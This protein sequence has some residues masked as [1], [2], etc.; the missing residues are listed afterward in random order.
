M[1]LKT[2][3]LSIGYNNNTLY[4]NLN[5]TL[6]A[7]SVT[8]M[9]GVNGSGKST[10][11]KT[12]CGFVPP[13]HG[14]ILYS[15]KSITHYT[16]SELASIL[17]VVLTDRDVNGGLRVMEVVAM[18]RYPYTN[19]FGT[20]SKI[21]I[22]IIHSSMVDVGIEHLKDRFMS[23]L[24]DGER[25]KVMIAKSLSQQSKLIIL[26]E[27]TSFLD[28]KS[29]MEIVTLLRKL[30]KEKNRTFLLSLHDLELSLQYADY[31]WILSKG[32]GV[33]CGSTDEMVLSSDMDKAVG[34]GVTFDNEKGVYVPINCDGVAI[35]YEGKELIWIKNALRREGYIIDSNSDTTIKA[36]SYDKIVVN[37]TMCTSIAD[38]LKELK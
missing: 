20:L 37:G 33:I 15:E 35:R 34:S 5:L 12:L 10:L 27:P 22:D 14:D 23:E 13:L 16:K 1:I 30:A 29:R 7:G 32:E 11:I 24:S 19:F 9:L 2:D 25:Q 38:M 17:S 21:D 36:Y 31:L 6:R 26:D 8:A 4:T 18:G 28:I 3:N